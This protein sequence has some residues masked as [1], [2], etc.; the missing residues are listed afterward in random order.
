MFWPTSVLPVKTL[1]VPSS[2]MCSQAL[3]SSRLGLT[4]DAIE[5]DVDAISDVLSEGLSALVANGALGSAVVGGIA[6][7]AVIGVGYLAGVV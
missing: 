4:H 6:V 7:I 5:V 3:I 2:P 1:T